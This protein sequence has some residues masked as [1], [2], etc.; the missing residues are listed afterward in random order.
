V[1]EPGVLLHLDLKSR[2]RVL[3][4]VHTGCDGW[5][6]PSPDGKRLAFIEWTS[7]GNLWMLRR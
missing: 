4:R 1:G 3:R 5:A 7:T 6:I 2:V